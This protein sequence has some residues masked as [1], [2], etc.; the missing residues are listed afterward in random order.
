MR[1][2]I[3]TPLEAE[4]VDRIVA[5]DRG[6]DVDFAPE[7]L[8]PPR[9]PSDHRG[10]PDWQRPAAGEARW[11][12][13][14]A[15]ADVLYGVPGDTGP[16]LAAALAHAP[17][18]SW[19]Q[20]TAAG[21]GEQVRAAGLAPA[22][23]S[24][25]AF[26]T[27]AG[28]HGGMLAEFV[29]FGLLALR[30]DARRL[31]EVRERRAWEHFSSGELAGSTLAIVGLGHIG[32]TT[33]RIARAFGMRV[34]GITRDG[35]PRPDADFVF[36]TAQMRAAFAQADAVVLTLPATEKTQGLVDAAALAALGRHAIV[37]NVG[38]GSVIDQT[39]LVRA[40]QTGA[41]AGAVLDV[42]DPEPLPGD[43]PLWTMPNVVFAPHTMALSIREN[44]RIVD[45]FCENIRRYADGR[46]LLNRIDPVE[47][48]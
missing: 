23:L 31:A 10:A 46:P 27:A 44:E 35:S 42:V 1:I 32:A 47:F 48:Y 4:L 25:I 14:L 20:A 11:L 18:V 41:L 37:C 45:L 39:A 13:L 6:N 26:T 38:R 17:R 5:A 43:N 36:P 22:T 40:L 19:V 2:L 3:A 33:A 7:L 8:P 29:F 12:E 28:V 34:I 15:H 21:A 24:R 9:Y 30:K 16:A